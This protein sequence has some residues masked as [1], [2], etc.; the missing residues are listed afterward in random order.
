M[1]EIDEMIF[2]RISEIA[3]WSLIILLMASI[4]ASRI[5]SDDKDIA[6]DRAQGSEERI[7]AILR[8]GESE[9][10]NAPVVLLNILRDGSESDRFRS[11]AV[12]SL[13]NLGEPRQEILQA[14]EDV[15]NEPDA[16]KNFHYTILM[17]L[18]KMKAIESL[19]LLSRALSS[20]SS[21]IRLKA[22]QALGALEN[23]GALKIIARYLKSEEDRMVRAEAIRAAGK[24]RSATA[25]AIL[26][27]S[28]RLDPA[29]LVRYNAALML[30]QFKQM[31][32]ETQE[33]IKAAEND[34]SPVVRDAVRG[35][36]P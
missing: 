6:T 16:G 21:M 22:Y 25:E 35:I 14:F 7:K 17:S 19:P 12:L 15:Y 4:P 11:S 30:G 13:A 23:E 32:R 36:F 29:P 24:S 1:K 18:G 3:S 34:E 31:G 9:S 28:L 10:E 33:A 2:K 26:V 5:F 27:E 8:L 20:P